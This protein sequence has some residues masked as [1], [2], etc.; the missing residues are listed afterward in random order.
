MFDLFANEFNLNHAS[1]NVMY[2]TTH[3]VLASPNY[4]NAQDAPP[5]V[6]KARREIYAK[7]ARGGGWW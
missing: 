2:L 6:I 5:D 4:L 3:V 7:M 1:G